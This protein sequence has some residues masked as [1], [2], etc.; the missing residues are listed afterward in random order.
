M[1]RIRSITRLLPLAVAALALQACTGGPFDPSGAR[2]ELRAGRAL[3]ERE[4]LADYAYTIRR[5]CFCG[6]AVSGPVRVEVRGGRT[7]SV[8]TLGGQSVAPG[9]FDRL[10]T[11]EEL[12]EAVEDAI[13][14]EPYQLASAY[15][16]ARGHPV[17]LAVD[18]DRYAVDE[19]NG[20]QV[21]D[22]VALR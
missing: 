4:G 13:R 10:D 14:A 5:T 1:P 3:W 9:A 8:S 16:P 18:Y 6:P 11:V 19:E 2:A 15:D 20:F 21:T 12:F 22:F 17:A 7:V